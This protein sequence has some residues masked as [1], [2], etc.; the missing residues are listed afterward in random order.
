MRE[1]DR[2]KNGMDFPKLYYPEVY[3]LD[4]GYKA[5]Y[6]HCSVRDI[7]HTL[8]VILPEVTL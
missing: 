3:L 7:V 2:K 6:E 1:T 4:G 8:S 5:F